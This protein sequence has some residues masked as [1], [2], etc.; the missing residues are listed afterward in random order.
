MT[1]P[2]RLGK[3][4]LLERLHVGGIAEL[5]L[6]RATGIPGA[7]PLVALKKLL[8]TADEEL[9][10]L[11]V[12][13]ARIAAQLGHGNIAR[14]LEVGSQDDQ[15]FIAMEYISGRSLRALL[16][17]PMVGGRPMAVEQ[18]AYLAGELCEGLDYAHRKKDLQGR[19]LGIVHRG[20]SPENVLLTYDGGVKLVD[21]GMAKAAS[22]S[23]HT[24]AG[25]LKGKFG[26]MS[27]E[28]MLGQPLDRRSDLFSV[29]VV[30]FEMLTGTNP[31]VADSDLESMRRVSE[32]E[33]PAPR[34]L[35]P[36]LP[37]AMEALLLKAL[38]KEPAARFQWASELQQ[39]L[40]PFT[41]AEGGGSF[42]SQQLGEVMS[43][44]FGED[45]ERDAERLRRLSEYQEPKA[46]LGPERIASPGMSGRAETPPAVLSAPAPLLPFD[47]GE[48]DASDRTQIVM[49]PRFDPPLPGPD[50]P[51]PPP[52]PPPTP[53]RRTRTSQTAL[54]A[55]RGSGARVA[56]RR[57]TGSNPS[58]P[59]G[60][61]PRPQPE[62]TPTPPPAPP[63]PELE[64]EDPYEVTR[65]GFEVGADVLAPAPEAAPQARPS[66]SPALGEAASRFVRSRNG[67]IAIVAGVVLLLGLLFFA[68]R[69]GGPS[70]STVRVTVVPAE[71]A[72]VTI[73][74]RLVEI[75]KPTQLP[76]GQYD[77]VAVAPGFKQHL[78]KIAVFANEPEAVFTVLLEPETPPV[79]TPPV[80]ATPTPKPPP[81]SDAPS[82]IFTAKFV[83][84]DPGVEISVE[85]KPV[86][87]TPDA[88]VTLPVGSAYRYE[89]RREGYE[90]ARGLFGSS[91]ERN[92]TVTVA[93][94]KAAAHPAPVHHAAPKAGKSAA[95]GGLVC[96]SQP[97]G[98]R[99]EIDGRAT[100]TT[101]P[102]YPDDPLMLPVGR[103]RVVFVLGGKRSAPHT[104]NVEKDKLVFLKDV[105]IAGAKSSGG[106]GL[107]SPE[108]M[109]P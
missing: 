11:F 15:Y 44:F 18:A 74:G 106:G 66:S 60:S 82:Q 94:K 5:Y 2:T 68:T 57:P 69:P 4:L 42:S 50:E 36:D 63:P 29:G 28:Q 96:S 35:N 39:A 38:A 83:S 12:D 103:H 79:V 92:V 19:E 8:P 16:Q 98:A 51:T 6:A 3:Y 70:T 81:T 75:G 17:S 99:V 37:E 107:D 109:T 41:L 43:T 55:Q 30:L 7:E 61:G 40:L 64:P 88:E 10:S 76:P 100:R 49:A 87:K 86:G 9:I 84:V 85:G 53:P 24:Q 105:A 14:M 25:S 95:K 59:R 21:F 54:P 23:H 58:L 56:G 31:F 104:V 65:P 46:P 72:Q 45:A 34:S 80:T 20:V 71:K 97:N 91:G 108:M 101:T 48:Q 93:L 73:G 77:L 62:R 33:V 1:A 26:Y 89:A 102:V 27:P 90:V 78:Q 22:S 47:F 67:K 13:E 52:G 32:A